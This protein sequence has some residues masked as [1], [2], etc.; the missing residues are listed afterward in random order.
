MS[1][2]TI[3]TTA[4]GATLAFYP[5]WAVPPMIFE[6][7]MTVALGVL[8]IWARE[9]YKHYDSE[10]PMETS[11]TRL[12]AMVI[13]GAFSG[14]LGGEIAQL[15]GYNPSDMQDPSWLFV[16]IIG[17]GGMQVVDPIVQ[18]VSGILMKTLERWGIDFEK[19]Q[20]RKMAQVEDDD[21]RA[22]E[23]R[24]RLYSQEKETQERMHKAQMAELEKA[25]NEPA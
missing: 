4:A 11:F 17:F 22:S 14:I 18:A 23:T 3:V 5:E 19:Q 24:E 16:L 7:L 6:I 25:L 1:T 12:S 13:P 20:A 21:R 2:S 10:S 15:A 9:I 8:G